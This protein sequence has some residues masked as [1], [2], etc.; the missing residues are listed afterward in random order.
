LRLKISA[1]EQRGNIKCCVL[2]QKSPSE[3][4]QMLEEAYGKLA[5]KN[6][7]GLLVP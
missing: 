5:M 6:T 7:Q 4:F 2:Q 3:K 1:T